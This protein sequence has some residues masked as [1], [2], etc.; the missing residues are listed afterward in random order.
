LERLGPKKQSNGED[1]ERWAPDCL[2]FFLTY[3][4]GRTN[5]T[6]DIV[7]RALADHMQF[8]F[9]THHYTL[10]RLKELSIYNGNIQKS[11]SI[12]ISKDDDVDLMSRIL[13]NIKTDAMNAYGGM[14]VR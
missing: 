4:S 7:G 12:D 1:D 14:C 9:R 3:F 11:Y 2:L 10:D 6:I 5:I 8:H 13:G